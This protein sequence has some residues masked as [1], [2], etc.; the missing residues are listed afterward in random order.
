MAFTIDAQP[1]GP[2][3]ATSARAAHWS[4]RTLLICLVL[5]CLLPGVIG[6]SA[7]FIREY[8]EEEAR[9]ERD[10]TQ[11]ARALAQAVDNQILQ[12][13][14]M[15]RGLATADSLLARD[16]GRFYERA[17]RA[18]DQS[19]LG[20]SIALV[21]D[22]G[23]QLMNTS[24]KLGDDLPVYG[25][26]EVIHRVYDTGTPAVS[27]IFVDPLLHRPVLA[28]TV[29]VLQ[30]G[31]VVHALAITIL[32]EGF[33]ASLAALGLPSNW[34]GTILDQS[35]TIV[36]R[37]REQARWVG[38]K[39]AD[40]F[41]RVFEESREGMVDAVLKDGVPVRTIYTSS[42][43]TNWTV[44]ISIPKEALNARWLRSVVF[45]AAGV[46]GL[47]ILGI[48]IAWLIA[49]NIARSFRALT[50]PALALG[51]GG[52]VSLPAVS[53]KEADEVTKAM[54]EA[55]RLLEHRRVALLQSEIRLHA[56]TRH[57]PAAIA[58][59]DRNM[60]Y[61]ALSNRWISVYG[62]AEQHLI[63]KSHYDIFPEIPEAWKLAH[64]R[65]LAGEVL[66]SEAD[67]FE[68]A[69]GS[70]QWNR[71]EIW[72]WFDDTGAVGGIVIAV[73]DITERMHSDERV[74]ASEEKYR[75]LFT[76]MTEGFI[77]G[78]PVRNEQGQ[79]VDVRFVEVNEAFYRQTGLTPGLLG[80]P[81]REVLPQVEQHWIDR[82]ANVALSGKADRFE[83]YNTDTQR[84][85][86]VYAFSP[87]P[88][89]F[90]SLFRDVTEQKRIEKALQE[91]E[92][93]LRQLIA[94]LPGMV[95]T[96]TPDGQIDFVS[97]QWLDYTGT[98][99]ESQLGHAGW[100]RLHPADR[101]SAQAVWRHA[102]QQ[103]SAFHAE[104]R[105][106]RHD[107]QYRWFHSRGTVMRDHAGKIVRWLGVITD[108]DDLKRAQ[109]ALQ[110]SEQRYKALF[111]TRTNAI[112]HCRVISDEHRRPVNHRIEAVNAAYERTLGVE[113]SR[114]EGRLVTDAFPGI[115]QFDFDFI[116]KLGRIGLE[117][118]EEHF[119]IRFPPTG[120]WLSLYVYSPIEGEF[121]AI[122]TDVTH[123]KDIE[124]ALRKSE[125]SYRAL[126]EAMTE[127][128]AICEIILDDQGQPWDYRHL[129]VNPAFER[130][131]GY[132]P[133]V[134]N[135]KT[136]R[137]LVP[138]VEPYWIEM[139]GRVA[140]SGKP[141]TREDYT[142][143]LDKW[144][145]ARAFSLGGGKFAYLFH[146]IT[147]RKLAQER[148]RQAAQHDSLTG[149]PN[150]ALIFE[151]G[152]HLLAAARRNHTRGALLF[153]DLDRFKPVNDLYGHETGDRVL[154]EVAK[155]LRSCT[156]DEDV[157]GRLGGDEFVVILPHLEAGRHRAAAVAEHVIARISEPYRINELELTLSPS[158]G[159]SYFPD[160]ASDVGTLIH[161]ADMAMYQAKQSGRAN[162][163]FYTPEFDQ[164]A[165]QAL[166]LELKLKNAL[167]RGGLKLHYQPVIDVKSG[168]L[169]GAEALVRLA[170]DDGKAIGPDKFI[171]IAESSGLIADLG[172]WVAAEAC[173][174]HKT[175]LH[176]G[177]ALT[178][179]INVS[180][181]QFRQHGFAE[182]L[183][184][185][186]KRTDIDPAR[187]EIEVTESAV[188]EN[189]ADAVEILNK[190]KS[191]GMKVALDDF[192]TGY[193]SLSSLTSLPLDK[194]KVD[195]SFVRSIERDTAS[196]AV[197]EA[198]IAL[199]RSL[200]LE[201]HGEGIESEHALHYLAEHGCTQAQGYWF[202]APLP[203]LEFTE[204][205]RAHL[206]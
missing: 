119:E 187:I 148:V 168:K 123:Q 194:L 21:D 34:I 166:L 112:A 195:Q 111:N 90:A 51:S 83:S 110:D 89:R 31:Q 48:G 55:A 172:E 9:L 13:Q 20:T 160:Y 39:P 151:Y 53:V 24:R 8:R 35:I 96:T 56:L 154:Q 43:M 141:E 133:G 95:W 10:T 6:A 170:D 99:L 126:F 78:E 178:I 87:S 129:L 106:R 138:V 165:E 153:I 120:Q 68:R 139:F 93:Y 85:Y 131:G 205:C 50:A 201:V 121:T 80:R 193:S 74:R 118:G 185:I 102:I 12:V 116:G 37:S 54:G 4:V 181:V 94:T 40:I 75:T 33:S 198:I 36:A 137:E 17:L 162:Y 76:N 72:P 163:Q 130:I 180:P 204:W 192:G 58:V 157:V 183:S 152:N 14:A 28:L 184:N 82:Y 188:M 103:Q 115:D 15:A 104:Y 196:R 127:A 108:I 49:G 114:I 109:E 206:G 79:V 88:G 38:Q 42:P 171:P 145:S 169:I 179:A 125:E 122:F 32:P 1:N 150:R 59:F 107:G 155:R 202:S 3:A 147:D 77:L 47:F 73:E 177:M 70:V 2:T 71:W 52:P 197:T 189:V 81:L 25:N 132:L 159:V 173:R 203:P 57:A 63:G 27:S 41:I 124:T 167:K 175:W 19:N 105:L 91:S 16:F 11:T 23:R 135:G 45:L 26:L 142:A 156:R 174:Q 186:I 101:E 140:L 30:E 7:F 5:A 100:E 22:A 66:R 158:I 161:T 164:R 64:R 143:G 29:P 136:A 65:G 92:T 67:R 113:R 62:L 146:D 18:L 69:D 190:I 149:L 199:G 176:E 128:F 60:R 98:T 182:K 97:Q 44:A 84:H 46:L 144:F 86:D 134:V 61:L 191:L 200:K 117:G